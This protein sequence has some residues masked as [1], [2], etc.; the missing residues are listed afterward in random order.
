MKSGTWKWIRHSFAAASCAARQRVVE[1]RISA[2]A[3]RCRRSDDLV[4]VGRSRQTAAAARAASACRRGVRAE[5]HAQRRAELHAADANPGR[6]QTSISACRGSSYSTAKWQQSKQTWTCSSK[7]LAGL[8]VVRSRATAASERRAGRQQSLREE[9]Q[10]F[11][12][13]FERAVGFGLDVE[14]DRTA[15]GRRVARTSVSATRTTFA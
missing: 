12:A 9:G 3:C 1:I 5:M 4:Q 7:P 11:V 15:I 6:P 13:G 2:A 8:V 14:V 10:R